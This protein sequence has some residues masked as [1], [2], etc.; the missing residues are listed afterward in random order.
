MTSVEQ[1]F[2]LYDLLKK[3]PTSETFTVP[4]AILK[5]KAHR[6]QLAESKPQCRRMTK[7]QFTDYVLQRVEHLKNR[8][9][10][11]SK[12]SIAGN[13]SFIIGED[14]LLEPKKWK[15]VREGHRALTDAELKEEGQTQEE[16][17]N[18]IEGYAKIQDVPFYVDEFWYAGDIPQIILKKQFQGKDKPFLNLLKKRIS[19]PTEEMEN[20]VGLYRKVPG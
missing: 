15:W 12:W 20:G 18:L 1:T 13:K 11:W 5:E 8:L 14:F 19:V 16:R 7:A 3:N 2:E 6:Y 10:N 17:L 9:S 4:N